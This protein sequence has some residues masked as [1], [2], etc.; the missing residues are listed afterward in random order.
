MNIPPPAAEHLA[1][2]TERLCFA[3]FLQATANL[4]S[5][6][7]YEPF[8]PRLNLDSRKVTA[9][10]GFAAGLKEQLVEMMKQ[11]VEERRLQLKP[12]EHAGASFTAPVR[13]FTDLANLALLTS[14]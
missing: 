7:Q 1:T 12:L 9:T 13:H 11:P 5:A 8:S 3:V 6:A 2:F 10:L 4:P 14:K